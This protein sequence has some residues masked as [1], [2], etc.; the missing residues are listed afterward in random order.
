VAIL[1]VYH[2]AL[3]QRLN[4]KCN[5]HTT[6]RSLEGLKWCLQIY[7]ARQRVASLIDCMIPR[8]SNMPGFFGDGGTGYWGLNSGPSI[9]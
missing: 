1:T 2:V 6:F 4:G 8:K 3:G 5:Y 7:S 9:C